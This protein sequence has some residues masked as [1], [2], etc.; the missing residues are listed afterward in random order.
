MNPWATVVAGLGGATIAGII[1]LILDKRR[2]ESDWEIRNEA[3]ER[4]D[5]YRSEQFKREDEIRAQQMSIEA[6]KQWAK[7]L[8][9]LA[10]QAI[11]DCKRLSNFRWEVVDTGDDRFLTMNSNSDDHLFVGASLDAV[12]DQLTM[13]ASSETV[14]HFELMREAG[15]DLS[16]ISVDRYGLSNDEAQQKGYTYE[17]ISERLAAAREVFLASVRKDIQLD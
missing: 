5:R 4:D 2:R 9:D 1:A 8:R 11:S 3:R 15:R 6:R 17:A 10:S 14:K 13:L 12:F 7:E 16:R